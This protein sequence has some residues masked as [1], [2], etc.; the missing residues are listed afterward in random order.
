MIESA[1]PMFMPNACIYCPKNQYF[2]DVVAFLLWNWLTIY[3]SFLRMNPICLN[4]VNQKQFQC[5]G[6]DEFVTLLGTWGQNF[7]SLGLS[8]GEGTMSLP[9]SYGKVP[10]FY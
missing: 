3:I 8:A 4:L 2:K 9:V 7:W 1:L 6:R 10:L 5:S